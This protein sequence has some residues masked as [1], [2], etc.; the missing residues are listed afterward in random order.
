MS[1]FDGF[2]SG[3][4]KITPFVTTILLLRL[5]KFPYRMNFA[6]GILET[7]KQHYSHLK[8]LLKPLP[9]ETPTEIE[10]SPH[11]KLR[12]TLFDANHCPGA[13][14]FLVEGDGKAILYTGDIRAKPWRV[15]SLS[16]NPVLLVY[17]MKHERLNKV[18]LDTAFA[19]AKRSIY[20]KFPTK[21]EGLSELIQKISRYPAKTVFH[22][23]SWTLG[24]EKVWVTLSSTFGSKVHVDD[25]KKTLCDLL[26]STSEKYLL[27]KEGLAL[28]GYPCG[29]TKQ[30]GCLT[31]NPDVWFHTCELATNCSKLNIENVVWIIP[32]VSRTEDGQEL[33]EVGAGGGLGDFRQVHELEL[34]DETAVY[35]LRALLHKELMD[36]SVEE[37]IFDMIRTAKNSDSKALLVDISLAGDFGDVPPKE[38]VNILLSK[39]LKETEMHVRKSQESIGNPQATLPDRITLPYSRHSSYDELCHFLSVFRPCDIFPCS[40]NP[41]NWDDNTTS[42]KALFSHLCSST[43]FSHDEQMRLFQV[44]SPTIASKKH[45]RDEDMSDTQE[46]MQEYDSEPEPSPSR[47]HT[48]AYHSE[49]VASGGDQINAFQLKSLN[50][51]IAKPTRIYPLKNDYSHARND[52]QLYN[53][54]PAALRINPGLEGPRLCKPSSDEKFSA[55]LLKTPSTSSSIPTSSTTL[56]FIPDTASRKSPNRTSSPDSSA[57]AKPGLGRTLSSNESVAE[58]TESSGLYQCRWS[59]CVENF[60]TFGMLSNHVSGA[61]SRSITVHGTSTFFCLWRNCNGSEHVY[62]AT[63]SDLGG[64]LDSIHYRQELVEVEKA[65]RILCDL[66]E[67][68]GQAITPYRQL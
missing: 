38:L 66:E 29:N 45:Q 58:D 26:G 67:T 27:T 53:P 52:V 8:K 21:A 55:R 20:K 16:R 43:S 7:R 62:F 60:R 61:H 1:T 47:H 18:Y 5:E 35:S 6:R 19:V 13:V 57:V 31:S 48:S 40:V 23:N 64:H 50:T 32:V 15:N 9:L 24:Y 17:A 49:K 36:N 41:E 22:M 54:H 51:P 68:F 63:E 37:T 42:I 4:L 14:I 30:E 65:K 44:N 25:Y 33:L 46:T 3:K 34:H 10:L 56:Q 39:A 59:D 28:G 12:V 11:E 2:V